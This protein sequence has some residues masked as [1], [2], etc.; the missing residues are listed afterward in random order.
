MLLIVV[1]DKSNVL[2]IVQGLP[3]V[4]V[5]CLLVKKVGDETAGF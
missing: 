4:S 1:C 5:A 2:H 3:L